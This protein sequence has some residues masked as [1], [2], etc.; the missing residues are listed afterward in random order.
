MAHEFP[1]ESLPVDLSDDDAIEAAYRSDLD[2]IQNKLSLGISVLIECEKQLTVHLFRALR[3]RFKAMPAGGPGLRLITGHAQN[4]ANDDVQVNQTLMQRL[5][6]QLQQAIFSGAGNEIIALPHLDI[7]TTTT[8]SG[9]SAETREAAALLYENPSAL[10]LGFKDPSFELPKVIE[11]VFALKLPLIGIT[12]DRLP[13]L[14]CQREARKFGSTTFNPYSLYKYVS[15]LNAI[16]LRQILRH[17]SNR[18]DYTP[19]SPNTRDDI[20]REIRQMTLVSDV[21]LPDIDLQEDVGGYD[22]VKQQIDKEILQLLAAKETSDDIEQI[23]YLEEIIPKGIIFWGPPG[24]GKTLFAKAIA[25]ALDATVTIVSGPELKSKWVGESEENLRRVFAQARKSAPALIVFD[26]LDSF[27]AA[28][29]TYAGSGVEHSMVNQMLTEMDG[30]RKEEMVFVIGT[31]NFVESL[32]SALMRPGRFELSIHISAPREKDREAILKVY[33]EKFQISLSDEVRDY[34][35]Q[36]T[37]GFVDDINQMRYSGDHLYAMMRA[38]KREELRRNEGPLQTT[39]DDIDSALSR[40]GEKGKKLEEKEEDTIAVHEAGHAILAYVLP[41][42]PTIE[43]ITIATGEED[44]LGYVMQAVKKNKY[45]TTEEELR[46]DICVMLGGREAERQLLG[47][48]SVGAYSDL[49][50]ANEV[51]RMM[52]EEL[53]M[54]SHLG[55]R[56]FNEPAMGG[57]SSIGSKRRRVAEETARE[58]DLEIQKILDFESI[59]AKEY[60]ERHQPELMELREKLMSEKTL[61]LDGLKAIFKDK[62]FKQD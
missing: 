22:K 8:R 43:K 10:F 28:R 25:T 31:T 48:I 2:E 13:Y 3:S 15:G 62:E 39:N 7:L 60:L 57:S 33:E 30:F 18:L 26:E 5:L 35:V 27:A 49:Q 41:H 20:L 42:C 47:K 36:K 9:L 46:D 21:D 23:R 55:A 58:V 37:G 50:R 59:R 11:S 1:I 53:G 52:I 19:A 29:G 54:S 6:Q 51:A 45:V 12:R 44:T 34:A 38:L 40:A 24:T 4:S 17:F 56:T 61:G 32:D 14:I 16:R